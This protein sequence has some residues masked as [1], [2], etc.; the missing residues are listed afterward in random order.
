VPE[1]DAMEKGI[2]EAALRKAALTL[3]PMTCPDDFRT[4]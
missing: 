1:D 4:S 3:G 2:S